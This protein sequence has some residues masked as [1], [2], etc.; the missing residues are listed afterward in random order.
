MSNWANVPAGKNKYDRITRGGVT[1]YWS[2]GPLG[3]GGSYQTPETL[4]AERQKAG[5]TPVDFSKYGTPKSAT[6]KP[7]AKPPVAPPA[8]KPPAA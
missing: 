5:L 3:F 1:K 6:V 8:A 4:N 7:A 2:P